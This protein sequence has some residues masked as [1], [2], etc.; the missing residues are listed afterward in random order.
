MVACRASQTDIVELLLVDEVTNL[1]AKN[2]VGH[3]YDPLLST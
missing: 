1:N 2:K 3:N